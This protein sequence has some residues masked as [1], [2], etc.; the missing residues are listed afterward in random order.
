MGKLS[1]KTAII[2][3]GS[4][5][6]GAAVAR[7][8]VQEGANVA[9]IDQTPNDDGS[10]RDYACRPLYLEMDVSDTTAWDAATRETQSRFGSIDILVNNA[11]L[12][13]PRPI[14]ETDAASLER[15]LKINVIGPFLGMKAVIPFMTRTGG[16]SI[17]NLSSG[18]AM[19]SL[20]GTFA[21]ASSKW[22]VR[23]MSRCAALDL[24]NECI[25]VNTL[26]PGIIDTPIFAD[27]P[28]AQIDFMRSLVP[29]KRLGA[30]DEVAKAALFLASDD[31]SY[32]TGAEISVC[33]G[34]NL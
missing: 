33:G 12:Y 30:P 14:Q 16:G 19:R 2:T 10:P 34:V 18:V 8:F 20:A 31:S 23:G 24:V 7:L 32:M 27:S 28:E 9:I 17:I 25:R 22:A 11:A 29:M 26:F 13:D 3:G 21:Y 15:H 5:G 1:G 4:S 6:I